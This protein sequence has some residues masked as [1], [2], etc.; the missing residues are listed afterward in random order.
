MVSQQ[1]RDSSSG[2]LS[3]FREQRIPVN[4]FWLQIYIRFSVSE[5]SPAVICFLVWCYY[6]E[7]AQEQ[8]KVRV[9]RALESM[10]REF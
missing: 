8:E 10:H 5:C 9:Q 6:R 3:R 4:A 2:R 1:I 7:W